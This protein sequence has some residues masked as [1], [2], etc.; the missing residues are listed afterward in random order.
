MQ[1]ILLIF[2]FSPYRGA[3]GLKDTYRTLLGKMYRIQRRKDDNDSFRD[4][5]HFVLYRI[6]KKTNQFNKSEMLPR[7]PINGYCFQLPIPLAETIMPHGTLQ[8]VKDNVQS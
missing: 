6:K 4:L 7:L 3:Q 2:L 5:R 1:V 8:N